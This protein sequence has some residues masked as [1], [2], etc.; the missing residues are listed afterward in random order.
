MSIHFSILIYLTAHRPHFHYSSPLCPQTQKTPLASFLSPIASPSDISAS[1]VS[2]PSS[3]EPTP[4]WD[5]IPAYEEHAPLHWDAD[6]WDIEA[7]SESDG[8]LTEGEDDLQF[9]VDGEL[10]SDTSNDW[11]WTFDGESSNVGSFDDDGDLISRHWMGI[12]SSNEENDND[13]NDDGSSDDDND[14]NDGS[15]NDDNDDD[16]GASQICDK[17]PYNKRCR[18]HDSLFW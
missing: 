17:M 15:G 1:F 7:A 8:D 16:G 10:D 11:P 3:R 9:L 18:L 4:K 2:H 13:E 12:D 5:P 14:D 6:G